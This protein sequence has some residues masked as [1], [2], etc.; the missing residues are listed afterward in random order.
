MSAL[1]PSGPTVRCAAAIWLAACFPWTISIADAQE[2]S[3]PSE[4]VL[5]VH[6]EMKR[7][8]FVESLECAL[9]HV[10]VA[11]VSTQDLKLALGRD[12]LAS[13]TQL[14]VQKVANAFAQATANDGGPR[15]FKYLFLPFDLKDAQYRYVFATSFSIARPASR[16][17]IMSTARLDTRNPN[18][19]K[20]QNGAQTAHRLYK[21]VLK[22]IARLAGL[23]SPDACILVFPRS[24]EELDLKSAE[25]CPDDRAAL[26]KAGILKPEADIGTGC[27]LV[28]SREEDSRLA[29]L[30]AGTDPRLR[31]PKP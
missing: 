29:N 9:K 21:L 10:L 11:P 3:A 5:Y 13:P 17:G 23:K 12:L 27:G 19:P 31:G 6:S 8:E 28:A 30:V 2:L 24:L 14:D 25:F 16:V 15:T 22:S 26:V 18:Y 1:C 20:E 7:T 4:V